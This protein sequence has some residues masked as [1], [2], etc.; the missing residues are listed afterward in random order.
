MGNT[1][2]SGTERTSGTGERKKQ[3]E[4][5]K[6]KTAKDRYEAIIREG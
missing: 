6:K 4:E 3:T 1:R 5:G 2:M